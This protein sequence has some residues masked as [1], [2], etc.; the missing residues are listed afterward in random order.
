MVALALI[1]RIEMDDDVA[2]VLIVAEERCLDLIMDSV[3][4]LDV[5]IAWHREVEID[6]STRS[7]TPAPKSV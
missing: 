3:N 4:L 6:M 2:A 1:A 7:G 5:E